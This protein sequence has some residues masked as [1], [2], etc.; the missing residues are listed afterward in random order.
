MIKN[1]TLVTPYFAPAWSYGGPPKFFF[2]LAKELIKKGIK[3]TVITTDALDHLRNNIDYETLDGIKIYR[4][5]TISNH[6]AYYQKLFLVP[7]LLS[8]TRKILDSSDVV[9]FSEIRP[10]INGHLFEYL[11]DK[12]IPYG[13]FAFGSIPIGYGIK[14]L[15]KKIF[16]YVW[17]K[18]FVKSASFRFA[19]TKHEQ[20]M[21]SQFFKVDINQTHLLP[22]AIEERKHYIDKKQIKNFC[23]KWK[24]IENDKVILFVGRLHYQK[25]VDILIE[26][27]KPLL[28]SSRNLKLLIVGRDDGEENHLKMMTMP[29]Y[30]EKIIFTGPL[31]GEDV[32]LAYQSSLCFA[33]TPRFYEETSL[34]A[35]EALSWS[36]PVVTTWQADI[37]FLTQYQAGYVVENKASKIGNTLR[38]LL[39]LTNQEMT[40]IS[41]RALKLIKDHY[42]PMVMAE[43]LLKLIDDYYHR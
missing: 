11:I 12:K 23:N 42:S 2:T 3:V 37:P 14:A 40:S 24:I 27:L 4:Y 41:K 25:G 29:K 33:M 26:A 36:R 13:I 22:L 35:L 30:R 10:I 21:Y 28:D 39:L 38:K 43:R 34:A 15:V 5:K 19:Q 31:Y 7:G 8:K 1:L 18:K 20:K 16:D 6:L 32:G 17:V 9:F